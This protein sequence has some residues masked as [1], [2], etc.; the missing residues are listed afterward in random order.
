M[1]RSNWDHHDLWE[2]MAVKHGMIPYWPADMDEAS[3]AETMRQF[4]RS[5]YPIWASIYNRGL[6]IEKKSNDKADD[7]IEID[8]I[9]R[10]DVAVHGSGHRPNRNFLTKKQGDAL[11]KKAVIGDRFREAMS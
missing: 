6:E 1:K 3:K 5:I 2:Q 4:E 8:V 7:F 10:C 11:R 9:H